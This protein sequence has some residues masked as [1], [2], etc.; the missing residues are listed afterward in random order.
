MNHIGQQFLKVLKND[1]TNKSLLCAR[2]RTLSYKSAYSLE[3]LYPKSNLNLSSPNFLA[4]DPSAK[5][6]GYIPIKEIDVTYSSSSGPGGQNVNRVSTKVDLRFKVEDASWLS[7]EIKEKLLE[8]HP[9]QINKNGYLIIKSDLTRSQQLNLADALHKLR[10]MIRNLI[11]VPSE[12]C[13][14]TQEK[15]RKKQI[16]AAQE[17]VFAKRR[18]SQTKSDRQGPSVYDSL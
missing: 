12:P 9:N 8:K 15:H 6:S 18:R 1:L 14:L 10:Q 3:N 11:E 7:N 5:F 4:K 2:G 13:E 17:R 16:K